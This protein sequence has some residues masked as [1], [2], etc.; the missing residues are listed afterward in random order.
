MGF[1]GLCKYLSKNFA[2]RR[3]AVP[4]LIA[5]RFRRAAPCAM[6]D[7]AF[8]PSALVVIFHILFNDYRIYCRIS[9]KGLNFHNRNANGLRK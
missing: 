3:R 5:P 8:S 4:E 6:D 2:D 7:R 1:F 9:P